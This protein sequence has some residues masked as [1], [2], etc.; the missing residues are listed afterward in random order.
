METN[1]SMGEACSD[2]TSNYQKLLLYQNSIWGKP[3]FLLVRREP[4]S[5]VFGNIVLSWMELCFCT[6]VAKP[7]TRAPARSLRH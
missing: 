4:Y 6:I 7:L 2:H 3:S 5:V 1:D